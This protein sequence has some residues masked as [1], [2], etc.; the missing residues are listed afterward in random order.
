MCANAGGFEIIASAANERPDVSSGS[1]HAFQQPS[2]IYMRLRGTI[3]ELIG[4][5]IT[6]V[7]IVRFLPMS[8]F[9]N[10]SIPGIKPKLQR[11]HS[12]CWKQHRETNLDLNA[13]FQR[14]LANQRI[15][16]LT[17]HHIAHEILRIPTNVEKFQSSVSNK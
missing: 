8:P 3:K 17:L 15:H 6:S 4:W 16:E 14:H 1:L 13:H 11:Y 12:N 5:P 7:S 9:V 2:I 10:D